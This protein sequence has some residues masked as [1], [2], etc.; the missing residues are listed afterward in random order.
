[1]Y[2]SVNWV[3]IGTGKGLSPVRHQDIIWTIADLLSI[4]LL[5]TDF[6]ETLIGIQAF[7]FKNMRLKISQQNFQ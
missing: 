1:M 6:S 3:S 5:G 4:V 2:A 7:S